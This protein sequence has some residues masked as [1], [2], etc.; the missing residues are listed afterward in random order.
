MVSCLGLCDKFS[1]YSTFTSH[2]RHLKPQRMLSS[3]YAMISTGGYGPRPVFRESPISAFKIAYG[4]FPRILPQ[5]GLNTA[6][7]CLL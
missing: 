1:M 5:S 2:S 7:L 4:I 6:D 3:C